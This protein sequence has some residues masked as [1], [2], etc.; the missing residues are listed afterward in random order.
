MWY[1]R[2]Q[3]TIL[4]TLKKN[5]HMHMLKF[6]GS[7][8]FAIICVVFAIAILLLSPEMS[9]GLWFLFGAA[10]F[11]AVIYAMIARSVYKEDRFE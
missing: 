1:P 8:F 4:L 2:G 9:G 5:I 10:L 6:F 3:E 7:V 11:G